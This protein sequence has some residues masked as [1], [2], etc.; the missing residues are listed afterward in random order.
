MSNRRRLRGR[1][2]V[3]SDLHCDHEDG[4]RLVL[5]DLAWD[6]PAGL[7]GSSTGAERRARA[8]DVS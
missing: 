8:E 6:L 1:H 5:V 3:L 7:V 2:Q 4:E